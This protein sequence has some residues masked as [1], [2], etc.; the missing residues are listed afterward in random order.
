[1]L[2]LFTGVCGD[3]CRC[4]FV[5]VLVCLSVR[6]ALGLRVC[7]ILLLWL[8]LGLRTVAV[9]LLSWLRL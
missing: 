5:V 2:H 6:F 4:S 1:M 7:V 8:L 3:L 9:M